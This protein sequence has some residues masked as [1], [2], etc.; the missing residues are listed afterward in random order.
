LNSALFEEIKRRQEQSS[1]SF[2]ITEAR[3]IKVLEHLENAKTKIKSARKEIRKAVKVAF[4][5]KEAGDDIANQVIS[6]IVNAQT[7]IFEDTTNLWSKRAQMLELW[8]PKL[9]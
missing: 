4:K 7:K 5:M 6:S 3:K 8:F 1:A 2:N 9:K